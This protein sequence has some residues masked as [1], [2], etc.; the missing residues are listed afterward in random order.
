M[1]HPF[2]DDGL[3]CGTINKA[4]SFGKLIYLQL[5]YRLIFRHGPVQISAVQKQTRR[6]INPDKTEN[7]IW[8]ETWNTKR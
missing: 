3:Y 7:D 4:P 2:R 8:Y 1:V 6:R 5:K